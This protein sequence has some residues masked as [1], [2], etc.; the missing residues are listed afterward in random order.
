[1]ILCWCCGSVDLEKVVGLGILAPPTRGSSCLELSSTPQL[2]H[3][4]PFPSPSITPLTS[5]Q[6][7]LGLPKCRGDTILG[8]VAEPSLFATPLTRVPDYHLLS[9]GSPLPGRICARSYLAR[10]NGI[11]HSRTRWHRTGS[12]EEG[13]QQASG[14]GHISGEALHS[15]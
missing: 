12:R 9:R 8:F 2:L 6:Y 1:M 3:T 10:R 13:H 7:L 5:L 4:P 14:A 15:Q 11:R